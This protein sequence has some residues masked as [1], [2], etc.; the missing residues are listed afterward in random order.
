MQAIVMTGIGGPEVLV[1]REV[2]A[3][4]PHAGDVMIRTEAV[5]VLY[6]ETLLRSGVFPMAAAPPVVFGFQAAGAVVEVGAGVD[7]G[8]VGRRVVVDTTGTGSYAEFV[9]AP[10]DSATP[11][12]EGIAADEAAAAVMSGS[13]A[14]TLLEAAGL[15]GTETILVEAGATG[16]GS[17][18]VQLAKDFGAARVIATAGG[19]T[20]AQRARELGADEVIDHR[21]PRWTNTLRERLGPATVD[22]VFDSIGG[23]STLELL[24]A[25]T[26]GRGRILGYGWLSGAPAEVSAADLLPRGLTFTGCAGPAWLARVAASRGAILDRVPSLAPAVEQTLPLEQADQA[27][28]L[29]ESRTPLGKIILRPG[30]DH[31]A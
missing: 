25:T 28:Q 7:P 27:H 1:A 23:S 26:P 30:S 6:P 31:P 5:P 29:V 2:P 14:I 9:C 20:K 16:V 17:Y 8:L 21:E 3:P 24:D 13:V 10:A 18:L 22:V 4:R 12:P 11:I 19:S 15:T